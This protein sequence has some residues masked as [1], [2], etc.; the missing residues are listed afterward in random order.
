MSPE[1]E[2]AK[3]R[4]AEET[5]P[6]K[7]KNSTQEARELVSRLQELKRERERIEREIPRAMVMKER[8]E[9]RTTH[10]LKRGQYDDPGAVVQR[11]APGFLNPLNKQGEVASRMDLAEW[12]VAPDNPLTAR[13]AVNRFWQQFFGIGLVKTSEDLGAQGEMPSHPQL[14]DF[15]TVSFIESGWN[16]KELIRLIVMSKAYRQTSVASAEQYRKDPENRLLARGSRFRMDAEMIRDQILFTSGLL[17]N[18]MYGRSVKPPQPDGLWKAVTMIGERFRP[19]SGDAIHRRSLYT[20]WKR[21]MPPPQMTIL[22]API[23]DA[24]TARRERTNTPS[25]ALLLLNESEYL[26]AA[27]QLALTALGPREA[28][29]V[30]RLAFLYET[31]TS[32]LPDPSEQKVLAELVDN[33]NKKYTANPELAD[34]ICSGVN[35]ENVDQKAQLAA[36]TVLVNT[37]YN[38]DITKTRE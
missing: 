6:E 2:V 18:K 15:L 25:Q 5:D 21:G 17:V 30:Q 26:K 27:R 13:V 33:L 23:R 32:K 20:Y 36:W 3:K 31:V 35:I 7:K 14:L 24:C 9:V 1:V 28:T 8:Q 11:D 12:F 34:Q 4:A 10:I 38:L 16:I 37:L 22:N 29:T 19:D